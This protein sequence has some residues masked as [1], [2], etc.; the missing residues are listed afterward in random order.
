MGEILDF[1]C[2]DIL[3]SV[4]WAKFSLIWIHCPLNRPMFK[5]VDLSFPNFK[6]YLFGLIPKWGYIGEKTQSCPFIITVNAMDRDSLD[7][8]LYGIEQMRWNPGVKQSN[9][10]LQLFHVLTLLTHFSS[11]YSLRTSQPSSSRPTRRWQLCLLLYWTAPFNPRPIQ[12]GRTAGC[13]GGR[14]STSI[15][16]T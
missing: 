6:N 8:I 2:R 15:A 9:Y 1:H 5:S 12:L 4:S 11:D 14:S 7:H 10:M 16:A 13:T 3:Q